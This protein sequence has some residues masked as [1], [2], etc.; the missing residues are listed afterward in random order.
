MNNSKRESERQVLN[1]FDKVFDDYND[2]KITKEQMLEKCSVLY[3]K[4]ELSYK[5]R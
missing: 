5:D 4:L 1:Q 2:K 3:K